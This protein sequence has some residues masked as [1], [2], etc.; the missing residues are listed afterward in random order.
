MSARDEG[1]E[2]PSGWFR[3]G[4]SSQG[5]GEAAML[6]ARDIGNSR[7]KWQALT[8]STL[9]SKPNGLTDISEGGFNGL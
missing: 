5:A 2:K 7:N 6:A 8:K 9:M 4:P 3:Q 1:A